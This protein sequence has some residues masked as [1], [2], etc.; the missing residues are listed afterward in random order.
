[1]DSMHELADRLPR[2][3]RGTQYWLVTGPFTEVSAVVAR[4][5][6]LADGATYAEN[7]TTGTAPDVPPAADATAELAA[8]VRQLAG[9][10]QT[11]LDTMAKPAAAAPPEEDQELRHRLDAACRVFGRAR[12]YLSPG[13]RSRW[14][15]LLGSR[16]RL[17]L[18]ELARLEPTSLLLTSENVERWERA[19]V[20]LRAAARA[21]GPD[22]GNQICQGG[23]DDFLA[24]I[25]E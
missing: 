18:D 13:G 16:A 3:F 20:A 25:R 1:M 15:G 5:K 22:A 4:R 12:E 21:H 24:W 8:A 23:L 14:V 19:V 6:A 17:Y 7:V 2:A 9:L 10:M 11:Y